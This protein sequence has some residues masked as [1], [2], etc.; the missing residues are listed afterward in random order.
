MKT[1]LLR[2]TLGLLAVSLTACTQH[3]ATSGYVVDTD[4]VKSVETA[5]R[6]SN[7]R[8]DVIWINPPL[9]RKNTKKND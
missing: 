3:S 9:K 1:L 5:A 6:L 4:K 2:L 8:V 7:Q